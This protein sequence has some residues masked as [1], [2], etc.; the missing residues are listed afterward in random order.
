MKSKN[1]NF[2]RNLITNNNDNNK[3]LEEKYKKILKYTDTELN[4]L[5][6]KHA[7]IKDQ[8]TYIQYYISLLKKNQIIIFS[9]YCNEK[10]YNPQMIK[11]FLFF[12]FYNVN[13][14]VNALFFNDST[15]HK[16]FIDEGDYNFIYQLPNIIYSAIFSGVINSII[17]FLSLPEKNII[18]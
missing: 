3:K 18:E 1:D 4:S 7:L 15:M 10:D 6:Y 2:L 9:F 11:I 14:V 12:F 13:F 8:R 5:D 17:K 16:I